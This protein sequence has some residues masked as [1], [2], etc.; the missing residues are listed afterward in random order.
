MEVTDNSPEM[1]PQSM[2]KQMGGRHR[3]RGNGHKAVCACPI[4]KNM[5]RSKR[6]GADDEEP[7]MTS[8]LVP[9]QSDI[10]TG[11]INEYKEGNDEKVGGKRTR[12]HRKSRKS[13]KSKKSRKSRKSRS[14][15]RR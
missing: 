14:N 11:N 10:E 8:S 2:G 1:S 12:K 7:S 15:R 5:K 13:K 3:R 4:C 9:T 6:G